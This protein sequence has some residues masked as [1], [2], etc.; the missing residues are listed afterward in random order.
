MEQPW[1]KELLLVLWSKAE[2][3]TE[4]KELQG[5]SNGQVHRTNEQHVPKRTASE[6]LLHPSSKVVSRWPIS[7][8]LDIITNK[9]PKDNDTDNSASPKFAAI[10]LASLNDTSLDRH[11]ALATV[12][13]VS[14]IKFIWDSHKTCCHFVCNV[15]AGICQWF[16]FD[17]WAQGHHDDKPKEWKRVDNR[18]VK[19]SKSV[20]LSSWL[21]RVSWAF[22]G[23]WEGATQQLTTMSYCTASTKLQDS[24][25][26]HFFIDKVA[27]A[28]HCSLHFSYPLRCQTTVLIC[29]F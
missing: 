22:F 10:K 17:A 12:V 27:L 19:T 3:A 24:V 13:V 15:L 8:S 4:S 28:V 16:P 11:V 5:P 1:Q 26:V 6:I 18:E 20:E 23:H 29:I 14:I 7:S 2:T 9:S 21:C 25:V